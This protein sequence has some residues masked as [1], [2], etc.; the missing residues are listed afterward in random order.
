MSVAIGSAIE[1]VIGDVEGVENKADNAG[2]SLLNDLGDAVFGSTAESET[3][4][5]PDI[6]P[7]PTTVTT[8]VNQ[9][10]RS[11]RP[12]GQDPFHDVPANEP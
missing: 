3:D 10:R 2:N 6:A 7:D 12:D 1:G 9:G 4:N 8:P 11:H 5:A